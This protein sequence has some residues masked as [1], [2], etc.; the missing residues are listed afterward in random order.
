MNKLLLFAGALAV[1]ATATAQPK[2]EQ[3]QPYALDNDNSQEEMTEAAQEEA[4][5][6]SPAEIRQS[7]K[8]SGVNPTPWYYRP[9]GAFWA[10]VITTDGNKSYST[11][12]APYIAAFPYKSSTYTNASANADSVQWAIQYNTAASWL[13]GALWWTPKTNR[14]A[15]TYGIEIDTVP[16]I[17]AFGNDTSITYQPVG[18]NG[19]TRKMAYVMTYPNYPGSL[20]TASAQQAWV[21][22]HFFG[23]K[24]NRTGTIKAGSYYTTVQDS[25]NQAAGKLFGKNSVGWNVIA[26][27]Y[28]APE[29]PYVIKKVGV[30]FQNLYLTDTVNGSAVFTA[31]IYKVNALP[32]YND[33]T[34]NVVSL[35]SAQVLG[36]A[37]FTATQA[38]MH[39]NFYYSTTSKQ[40]SGVMKFDIAAAN[41][42]TPLS[43]DSPIIVVVDGYNV[44]AVAD[45]T[46][47]RSSDLYDEG[48]G[49]LAY[50]G[51][52]KGTAA[53]TLIGLHN[54]YLNS[55]SYP[56][57]AIMLQIE[58]PFFDY[59]YNN[60]TGTY[61]FA[62]AGEDH[63]VQLYSYRPS[64]YWTFEN[65]PSWLTVAAT[66]SVSDGDYTHVTD[67]K[68]TAAANIDA[69][70]EATVKMTYPGADVDFVA[71]QGAK[72]TGV[73]DVAVSGIVAR[74][75]GGNF[76]I[77]ATEPSQAT[78]YNIAGQVV[79]VASLEAGSNVIDGQNLSN[80]VYIVRVGAK[81]VKVVK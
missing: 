6:L 81:S 38:S 67:V 46:S 26:Q 3:V 16:S 62:P 11:W 12:Y 34:Y 5:F 27:A 21:N 22:S 40:F 7:R 13:T 44:D 50:V 29:H 31:T 20:D 63:T 42:G 18:Y 51:V 49:E 60:E 75:E 54:S 45:F 37:T 56:G 61:E 52:K 76:V 59:N 66:D 9:A 35:A 8:V 48:F 41:G 57:L 4:H 73:K 36:K 2:V 15:V 74:V 70:R 69:Y 28:E 53:P 10:S 1:A 19:S 25:A 78:V 47:V 17:T 58:H 77:D 55:T 30:R 72:T 33:T 68:F 39:D 65:V 32:A 79:K 24:S 14:A 71:T 43:V 23:A 80:G 64:S